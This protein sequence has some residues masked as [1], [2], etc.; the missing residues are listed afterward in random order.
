[1]GS[2]SLT[3]GQAATQDGQGPK[4]G[5]VLRGAAADVQG[6][7]QAYGHQ[8]GWPAGQ[9]RPP[10]RRSPRSRSLPP[11][12]K[13][14]RLSLRRTPMPGRRRRR[15]RR[16]PSKLAVF[17]TFMPRLWLPLKGSQLSRLHIPNNKEDGQYEGRDRPHSKNI[18]GWYLTSTDISF[19][20]NSQFTNKVILL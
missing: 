6:L 5:R 15:R 19:I 1:M 18:V 10:S 16:P 9:E 2:C 11:L 4:W 7:L 13:P 14:L 3:S 20:I 12:R 8:Q 17:S